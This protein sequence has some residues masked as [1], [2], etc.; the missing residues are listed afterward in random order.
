MQFVLKATCA[1]SYLTLKHMGGGGGG[2]TKNF[3]VF[4][5]GLDQP[6][7]RRTKAYDQETLKE[8]V[9]KKN[10]KPC[11]GGVS[12]GAKVFPLLETSNS[13][14]RSLQPYSA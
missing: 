3:P 1:F 12:R 7:N 14:R 4:S 13:A 8:N 10:S 5:F 6:L 11:V 2:S 9:M